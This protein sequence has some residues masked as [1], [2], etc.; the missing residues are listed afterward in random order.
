MAP[1]YKIIQKEATSVD[2]HSYCL[3]ISIQL[4]QKETG[5]SDH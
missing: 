1:S 4:E 5:G 3:L 2:T